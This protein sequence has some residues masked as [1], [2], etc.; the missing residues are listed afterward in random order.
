M[1]QGLDDGPEESTTIR[2]ALAEEDEHEGYKNDN[3]GVGRGYKACPRDQRQQQRRHR[4]NGRPGGL[5]T[6]KE[7]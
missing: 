6:T 3:G 1:R 5:A 4:I 7:C 2:V